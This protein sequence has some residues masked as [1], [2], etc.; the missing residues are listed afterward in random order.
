ME[1]KYVPGDCKDNYSKKEIRIIE[2]HIRLFGLNSPERRNREIGRYC[3]NVIDHHNL[4]ED[5]LYYN[6]LVNLFRNKLQDLP[7]D[8]AVKVCKMIYSRALLQGLT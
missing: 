6:L 8:D 7:L 1:G 5:M 3:K 4:M 2:G